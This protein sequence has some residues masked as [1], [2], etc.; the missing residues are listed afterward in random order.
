MATSALAQKENREIRPELNLEQWQIWLPAK[1]K[2]KPEPRLL[3]KTIKT[4]SGEEIQASVEIGLSYRGT[5][6]TEDQKTYYALIELWEQNRNKKN[7]FVHFSLK[8]LL[9][10]L[11]KSWGTRN[12][13]TVKDSL[14]RLYGVSFI[15]Q[16]A[17]VE[18]PGKEAVESL[19]GF[20]IL[21]KLK[22][23]TRKSDGH[24]T[25]AEG[26]FR[27]DDSL[28]INLK[29]KF[30]RPVLFDVYLGFK[31]EIAQLLYS[32]LDRILAVKNFTYQKRTKELFN[33]LGL[34]GKSYQQR[35]NRKQIL[36]KAIVELVGLPMSNGAFLESVKLEETEDNKDFKLL[37]RRSKIYAKLHLPL[38]KSQKTAESESKSQGKRSEKQNTPYKPQS[39]AEELICKFEAKILDVEPQKPKSQHLEIV[40]EWIEQFGETGAETI[41]E[42]AINQLFPTRDNYH[43]FGIVKELSRKTIAKIK[44]QQTKI[45]EEK[46]Q[47]KEQED[48]QLAKEIF[49]TFSENEQI[50]L[51]KKYE[52]E[53]KRLHKLKKE[54]FEKNPYLEA[55]MSSYADE[56]I[57]Q[58]ILAEYQK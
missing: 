13:E 11:G 36:E 43:S 42:D 40:N 1:S 33:E 10:V 3:E 45:Q 58:K 2:L 51:R 29:N 48:F 55:D 8:S 22:I 20:R 39:L 16:F 37:A 35:S 14:S 18:S 15:W 28:L 50:K 26:Y 7:D 4:E 6:T 53:F 12:V 9:R 25:R 27:F 32:L 46:N 52:R 47:R 34:E 44:K 30:T 21:S 56:N 41:I 17:Y 57:Q 38:N 23:I 31:S 49:M 19:E 54:D 24:V 5:L